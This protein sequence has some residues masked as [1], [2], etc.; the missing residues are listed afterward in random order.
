MSDRE[1]EIVDVV[2]KECGKKEELRVENSF[3]SMASS[4]FAM[5]RSM[6]DACFNKQQ[7]EAS[8]ASE[9]ARKKEEEDRRARI[10]EDIIG[11]VGEKYRNCR[12]NTFAA[13]TRS[14]QSA[15]EVSRGFASAPD[16]FLYLYGKPGV[17][18]THLAVS[19][20][21]KYAMSLLSDDNGYT[22]YGASKSLFWSVPDLLLNVRSKIA[23]GMTEEDAIK[24]LVSRFLLVLDD[25]GAEKMT[26]WAKQSF[27]VVVSNRE[28]NFLPTVFTS[29]LSL[30][31]IESRIGDD[32]ITSRIGGSAKIVRIE[33]KDHR[34]TNRGAA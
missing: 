29:N 15:L 3:Y 20:Y 19:I 33:G 4:L 28:K 14:Q 31:E 34:L 21:K 2:C 27:Y 16:G 26:D 12:F 5:R 25:F 8:A 23:D 17:G 10:H 24:P 9:I 32:R 13:G 7:E 30:G 11:V 6:C 18:K 22:R 1:T